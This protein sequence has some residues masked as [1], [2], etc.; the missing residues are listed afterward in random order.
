MFYPKYTSLCKEK[1]LTPSGGAVAAGFSKG[2]VSTWKKKFD[3]GI[4][5]RP[6]KDV[7]EKIC[8]F[9]ECTE[10][11]LLDIES[12][13]VETNERTFSPT[14]ETIIKE[15]GDDTEA[16]KQALEYLRFIRR[17]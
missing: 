4:D 12:A 1:G 14:L 7:L 2:T 15:Y 3:E 13:P 5:V 11:W 10:S 6:E 17:Q 9:F 8:T 16:L